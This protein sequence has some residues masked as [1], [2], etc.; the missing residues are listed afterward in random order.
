MHIACYLGQDA[1]AIELVNAGANVNQPNDK[2]FTPL[3][4]AAVSTN[5]ALC[6]ELLV[7]NGADVNYQVPEGD[8]AEPSGERSLALG[9]LTISS[10]LGN[11]LGELSL[12]SWVDLARDLGESGL[13]R[14]PYDH[15]VLRDVSFVRGT[16]HSLCCALTKNKQK[17]CHVST[18]QRREK[19]SAHGCHPW[20][21]HPLPDSH[22]EWY[23]LG[24]L[25]SLLLPQ[26][27]HF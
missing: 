19:S 16:R 17:T 12:A 1:V 27:T 6:L 24:R 14:C 9:V 4:V 21:F 7:N 13:R 10:R 22:P 25:H 20:P 15:T 5:G 11:S 18:E 26:R 23:G 3:H 8:E 2:G